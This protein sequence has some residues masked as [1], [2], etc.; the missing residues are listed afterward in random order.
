MLTLINR[1]LATLSPSY[2]A[3]KLAQRIE[4]ERRIGFARYLARKAMIRAAL[5]EHV[6]VMARGDMP[7]WALMGPGYL[8]RACWLALPLIGAK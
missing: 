8:P 4:R 7:S 3:A 5:V 1:Y 2:R 6:E